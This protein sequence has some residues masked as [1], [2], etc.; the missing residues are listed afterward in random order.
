[1]A[2]LAS[3][4]EWLPLF[5]NAFQL[6]NQVFPPKS[7]KYET[8]CKHPTPE[9][10]ALRKTPQHN[11]KPTEAVIVVAFKKQCIS[12]VLPKFSLPRLLL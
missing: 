11:T 3:S 1:M 6:L 4:L 7:C 12:L 9:Q 5:K 2:E 10:G 8:A